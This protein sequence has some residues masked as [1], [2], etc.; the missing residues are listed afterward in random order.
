MSFNST[1][2]ELNRSESK[3]TCLKIMLTQF[4]IRIDQNRLPFTHNLVI[5]FLNSFVIDFF[6]SIPKANIF[7]NSGFSIISS[8][9]VFFRLCFLQIFY[10]FLFEELLSLDYSFCK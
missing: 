3:L 2:L 6:T 7:L 4:R 5:T 8:E 10:N 1:K 9:R